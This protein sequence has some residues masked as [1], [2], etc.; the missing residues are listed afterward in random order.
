MGEE[1]RSD[2]LSH[3]KAPASGRLEAAPPGPRP[4]PPAPRPHP[5]GPTP[6]P[7]GRT[8]RPPGPTPRPPGRTPRLAVPKTSLTAPDTPLGRDVPRCS[9]VCPAPPEVGP[10]LETMAFH[11][12]P[13][14]GP[15]RD[16]R[17]P[18][19]PGAST[20][21]PRYV[22][23]RTPAGNARNASLLLARR[24]CS[25]I[26]GRGAELGGRCRDEPPHKGAGRLWLSEPRGGG[27]K[28]VQAQDAPGGRC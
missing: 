23:R 4:H 17:P 15:R 9:S 20:R 14:S 13:S 6:R 8:P 28:E 10:P 16:Q 22:V 25:L 2:T 19:P 18:A 26:G 3:I 1:I 7:L 24:A 12:E 21:L 11:P 27:M 5:P